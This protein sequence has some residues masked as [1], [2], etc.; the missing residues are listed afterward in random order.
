MTGDITHPIVLMPRLPAM[1][2]AEKPFLTE[3]MNRKC[4]DHA[5]LSS[6]TSE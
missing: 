3:P 5:A 4:A 2:T 1:T 6:I